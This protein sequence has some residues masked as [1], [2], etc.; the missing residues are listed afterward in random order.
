[1]YVL[2]VYLLISGFNVYFK[3]LNLRT[4]TI[5]AFTIA[6]LLTSWIWLQML[7]ILPHQNH[8]LYVSAIFS[9][10]AILAALF[11]K[12]REPSLNALLP[13]T[14][15]KKYSK[16][17]I[18]CS[19]IVTLSI[20]HYLYLPLME[21]DPLEYFYMAKILLSTA[22]ASWYPSVSAEN[23]YGITAPFTHPLGYVSFIALNMV[24]IEDYIGQ[25]Y[26]AILISSKLACL[27]YPILTIFTIAHIL[28]IAN[29][30]KAIIWSILLYFSI[31][32]VMHYIVKC[33]VDPVRIAFMLVSSLLLYEL[34][35]SQYRYKNVVLLGLICGFSWFVHSSG[36]LNAFIIFAIYCLFVW[37]TRGFKLGFITG[38]ICVI[39][40]APVIVVD[41]YKIYSVLGSILGDTNNIEVIR[42]H[43][44][45]YN[46]FWAAMRGTT[47][48]FNLLRTFYE[49]KYWGIVYFL[50]VIG[51]ALNLKHL[52]ELNI[53]SVIFTVFAL[54]YLTAFIATAL[55]F[56]VFIFNPRYLMQPI[57]V[58]VIFSA[59]L[60][61]EALKN[62]KYIRI[63][64]TSVFIM[65]AAALILREFTT[66]R[67]I[68]SISLT[69]RDKLQ[70]VY[71]PFA[72][73][74][75]FI[76]QNNQ[77]DG[78]Y[79][80]LRQGEMLHYANAPIY[81]VYDQRIAY[82]ADIKNIESLNQESEKLGIKYLLNTYYQDPFITKSLFSKIA[83][84]EPIYV[85][86]HYALY[87]AFNSSK[88]ESINFKDIPYNVFLSG[89]AIRIEESRKPIFYSTNIKLTSYKKAPSTSLYHIA[90]E[91]PNTSK[92]SF[93]THDYISGVPVF[94]REYILEKGINKINISLSNST[95]SDAYLSF[96]YNNK[97]IKILGFSKAS[98]DYQDTT[99][100]NMTLPIKYYTK[101]NVFQT[102]PTVTCFLENSAC[103]I[104]L[105]NTDNIFID[106]QNLNPFK[107]VKISASGSGKM[108][109]RDK[110]SILSSINLFNNNLE[111]I[112]LSLQKEQDM[113]YKAIDSELYIVP[114][115]SNTPIKITQVKYDE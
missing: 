60:I 101:A 71:Q 110:S 66:I 113:R 40:S 34:M 27:Y 56:G 59:I 50:G 73:L 63:A 104:K 46:I 106:L 45:D 47:G 70:N 94:Q 109:I 29:K 64:F 58:M 51:I 89:S 52:K 5:L 99:N 16:E 68:I 81:Y 83:E 93:S 11:T 37:R 15:L 9:I 97:N 28:H 42:N 88:N 53:L 33:H 43:I 8:L 21:N 108:C 17:V 44:D 111:C 76:N 39:S 80:V 13:I 36:I 49:I 6:P 26:E 95:E 48:I 2:G 84:N 61:S 96:T 78:R 98:I 115:S 92:V 14:T 4:R 86:P 23:S 82:L 31:P 19:F 38:L 18:V 65:I 112:E 85:N 105:L 7:R 87:N 32:L 107:T 102:N 54:F 55:G 75:K 24:G 35:R 62:K 100:H 69:E 77:N 103:T 114:Y 79:I 41:L 3:E 25:N 12:Y 10:Y 1:M 57:F 91:S 72:E 90:I 67:S 22:D 20:L 30:Q 74:V